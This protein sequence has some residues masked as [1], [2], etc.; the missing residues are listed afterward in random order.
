LFHLKEK[1]FTSKNNK[2]GKKIII[3][4]LLQ[5]KISIIDDSFLNLINNIEYLRNNMK[6]MIKT[7][8]IDNL[9]YYIKEY[10]IQIPVWDI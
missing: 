10:N 8:K 1:K 2:N 5:C 4:K 3:E 9:N 6:N 7:N